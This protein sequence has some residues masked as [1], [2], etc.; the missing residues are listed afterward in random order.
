M[1]IFKLISKKS[2]PTSCVR[3][4]HSSSLNLAGTCSIDC[5][6]EAIN[7]SVLF[8]KYLFCGIAQVM[9]A[10]TKQ[11]YQ[12]ET[13]TSPLVLK[14]LS[15]MRWSCHAECCKTIVVKYEGIQSCL[16]EMMDSV[17]ENGE[18]QRKAQL[19][20]KAC[21]MET[22][23]ISILW[24]V[25]QERFDKTSVQLQKPGLNLLVPVNFLTFFANIC[26]KLT[27]SL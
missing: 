19:Y 16:K 17:E 21:S 22:A 23:F 18:T 20:K 10:S 7:I 25:I 4:M 13:K 6:M 9:E 8:R 1:K 12:K 27:V 2:K 24:N 5:C 14:T 3:A 15:G 26:H 11:S